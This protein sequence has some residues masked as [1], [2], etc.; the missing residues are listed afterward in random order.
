MILYVLMYVA[1][2]SLISCIVYYGSSRDSPKQ[3]ITHTNV[4]TDMNNALTEKF[5]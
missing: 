5:I 1:T 3:D 2:G 4:A